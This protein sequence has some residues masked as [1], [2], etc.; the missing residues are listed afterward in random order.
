MRLLHRPRGE[1]GGGLSTAIIDRRRATRA[2]N[3]SLVLDAD[4]HHPPEAAVA[5]ARTAMRNTV[6]VVLGTRYAGAGS[7]DAPHSVGRAVSASSLTRLAKT[8]FPRR[9]ATVSDPLSGLFAFRVAAIDLGRLNPVG[10]QAA[11]RDPGAAPVRAHRRGRLRGRPQA[12]WAV[13]HVGARG[14]HLPAAPRPAAPRAAHRPAPATA[15][16]AASSGAG[17]SAGCSRSGSS[18]CPASS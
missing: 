10:I 16:V 14:A 3:G 7:G 8:L 12:A 4:L 1:R 15:G 17:S 5:L 11:A 6:D 13:R 9:L 18:A 2:A